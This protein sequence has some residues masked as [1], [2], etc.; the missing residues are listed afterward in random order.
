VI[1]GH[2]ETINIEQLPKELT[3]SLEREPEQTVDIQ[4]PETGV[5][6]TDVEKEL[7]EQA[8]Q[9]AE[10]NQVHAARLLGISRDAFRSR[11]KKYNLL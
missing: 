6:L 3:S 2:G 11:L 8:L 9:L 4:L 5:R 1:L 10:G 7:V